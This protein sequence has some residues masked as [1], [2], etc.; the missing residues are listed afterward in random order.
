MAFLD[1]TGSFCS[2]LLPSIACGATIRLRHL[3]TKKYLHSHSNHMSPLSSN[4]EV[5]AYEGEDTGDD[6]KVICDGTA[7]YWERERGV[8]FQHGSL[9]VFFSALFS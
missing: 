7:K 6:W 4:Q 2:S 9:F 3:A 5:S 1:L 8:R